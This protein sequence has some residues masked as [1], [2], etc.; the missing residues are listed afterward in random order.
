MD[1]KKLSRRDFLRLSGLAAAGIIVTA[2]QQPAAPAVQPAEPAEEKAA[3]QAPAVETKEEGAPG[4]KDV[5]R[6]K[7]LILMFG[8]DGTQ[9]TD[10]GLGNPYAVGATHQNGSAALW[11]PLY[12]YSAF[13][14]EEIP[15]TATGYQYNDDYTELTINIRQGVEWSDGMPFTA[16]DVAF[17]LNMLRDN[18][19]MLNRSTIV[20][21]SVKEAIAV[22]DQTVQIIFTSPRPRFMFEQLS[23]K[24]DTGI[25]IVPEHVYKD[26]EDI[27][28]FEFYDPAKGWPLATGPY[29]IV[30]W[31]NTQKFHDRRDDWWAVKTGCVEMLPEVERILVIPRAD[32]TLMTQRIVN[33]EV[34]AILDLRAN[35]IGQ[36]VA[37]NP[38]IITHTGTEL[39]LGYIDW[40]P[41][42]M[43]FNHEDGPFTDK[44]M[45][46]AV[47]YSI[48]RQQMLDVG[49]QGSG[50]ITSLPFP[51]YPPLEPFFEAAKPLLEKYPTTEFNLDKAAA[52]MEEMGYAK[53]G[54]GFWV[55]DG[56]RVPTSMSG[57]QVFTDIGPIIAEQLRKGG[58]EAEFTTPADNGT[59]I[60]EGT[61]KIWLNGHGGS[62]ADPYTTMDFY[63][64]KYWAAIGEPTSQ[65]SRFKN[66]EYDAILDEMAKVPASSPGYMELYLAALEIWLDNLV[67][68]P[69]QQWLHRIPMNT[70]YW[71]NWPTAENPYVNGAF[72]HLT[73]PLILHKLE[74]AA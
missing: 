43:W 1:E 39:P 70:T 7:T 54:E 12:F 59:R 4:V 73:F 15:W 10:V 9:F 21:A 46:W 38:A 32:D 55:K 74:A 14:D 66:P 36:T 25:Y 23:F 40:W 31:T 30:E 50:I 2:C 56:Q 11:E 51:Q 68:S 8:G 5:P 41:T 72:W 27:A 34:D 13:A 57:W 17:T 53:D 44:R 45:R 62:I 49:L 19:P 20:Q 29:K 58:F 65:N 67:D 60:S 42:S 16:K 22:D 33:N 64:S 6:E 37:Q 61:Q 47:S 52:L 3:E 26:V 71:H 35:T 69:I 18:A 63:T 24:F 28:A 48:D